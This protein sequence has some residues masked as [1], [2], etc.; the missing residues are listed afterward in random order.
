V[1]KAEFGWR[2]WRPF[3]GLLLCV[4]LAGCFDIEQDLTVEGSGAGA[5]EVTLRIDPTF[6]G[7]LENETI[8]GDQVAPVVVK[9]E[10]KDGQYVQDERVTFNAISDLK[11]PNGT[12]SI[13]N[14]GSTFLGIGPQRLTL[15]RTIENSAAG[16]NSYAVMRNVF[17]DRTFTIKISV[18]GWIARAY[19]MTVA[20]QT[21]SPQV[22]G[23]TVTWQVPMARALS[24][25]NLIYRIDFLAY[26]SIDGNVTAQRAPDRFDSVASGVLRP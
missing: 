15:T 17:S 24:E 9:R 7:A 8:L 23:S 6:K 12:L 10:V 19:P 21:V 5:L 14:N 2:A 3:V 18:P 1:I 13:V 20:G 11:L 26:M 25:P 4:G 16:P 22:G